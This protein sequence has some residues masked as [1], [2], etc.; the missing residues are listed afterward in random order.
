MESLRE[1]LEE[2]LETIRQLRETLRPPNGA[3]FDGLVLTE[4]ERVLVTMLLAATLPCGRARLTDRV[5][6]ALNRAVAVGDGAVAVQI[7]RL[8]KKF[9][10]LDPPIAIS[11]AWKVGYW[12]ETIDKERLLE[13]RVDATKGTN[14]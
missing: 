13:R 4:T 14:S 11:S 8:R 2:A 12:M 5:G 10:A 3:R 7:C 9:R 1:Q 6:L